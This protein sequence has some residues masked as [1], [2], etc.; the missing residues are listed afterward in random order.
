MFSHPMNLLSCLNQILEQRPLDQVMLEQTLWLIGNLI[1]DSQQI[2]DVIV[3]HTCIF[4][5]LGALM[6]QK[7]ISSTMIKTITWV[8][9]N[10][11]RYKGLS[12]EQLAQA[13]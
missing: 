7:K 3:S 4:D 10:I 5:T 12:G 1:G 13:F 9:H 8:V 6:S 2:R 11:V